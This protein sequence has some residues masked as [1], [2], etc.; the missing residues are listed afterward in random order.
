MKSLTN[1]IKSDKSSL[2]SL[3]EKLIVNKDYKKYIKYYPST[4]D[5]LRQIILDRYEE[6]GP[7]T[8][9]KPIDFND[10]Y[11]GDMKSLNF[12]DTPLVGVFSGMSYE[13]IDVSN[14]DVSYVKDMSCVFSHCW[15][16]KELDLSDWDVSNV[17]DM[18]HMF[19]NCVDLQKLNISNWNVSNVTDMSNMFDSCID[20]HPLNIQNWNVTNVKD[21]TD[22][23]NGCKKDIVPKWYKNRK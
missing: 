17:K 8:K 10:I 13:Y 15:K 1:Y 14:W 21:I 12:G 11:I 20:L 23:F 19:D 7:G 4:T 16:I 5:E 9:N 22:M 3:S 2:I 18:S 6:Q